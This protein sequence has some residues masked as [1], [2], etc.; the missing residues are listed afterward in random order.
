MNAFLVFLLFRSSYRRCSI[1]IGAL[2]NFVNF[3][4][5][6][7]NLLPSVRFVIFNCVNNYSQSIIR[8]SYQ[9]CFVKKGVLN[10][11][12]QL[13]RILKVNIFANF[14]FGLFCIASFLH[15]NSQFYLIT[16]I[17]KSS[18]VFNVL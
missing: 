9:R 10:I 2:K 3:T 1:K 13:L 8:S 17:A 15:V 11:G 7:L 5:K 12:E 16:G 14:I 4:R 18:N 6:H